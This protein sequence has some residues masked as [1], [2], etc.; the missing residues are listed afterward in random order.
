MVTR[1]RPWIAAALALAIVGLGHAYLRRWGRALLWLVTVVGASVALHSVANVA[2][3]N[4]ITNPEGVPSVVLLPITALVVLSAIDAFV[5][6]KRDRN[7]ART[8]TVDRNAVNGQPGSHVDRQS[9]DTAATTGTE[10]PPTR[11]A[12]PAAPEETPAVTCPHC[13]K[14]TDAELDFCHW[15]TEPLPAAEENAVDGVERGS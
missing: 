2:P 7:R 6:G 3:V 11:N 12:V 10:R 4:P 13:G 14:E 5:L 8:A 15:C 9:G 1:L